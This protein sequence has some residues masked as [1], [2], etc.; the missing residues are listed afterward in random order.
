MSGTEPGPAAAPGGTDLD[1]LHGKSLE[2][3]GARPSSSFSSFLGGE[4]SRVC[5]CNICRAQ[6]CSAKVSRGANP[7]L[8]ISWWEMLRESWWLL[9]SPCLSS[10]SPGTANVVL[11]EEGRGEGEGL[12]NNLSSIPPWIQQAATGEE[13]GVQVPG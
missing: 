9:P 10:L 4:S 11:E 7:L 2:Y 3:S 5:W 8:G 1:G 6:G 12:R 13:H